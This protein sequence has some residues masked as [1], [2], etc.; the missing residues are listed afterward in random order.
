[1]GAEGIG[2]SGP[3]G[4]PE[5]VLFRLSAIT[6]NDLG[7]G[8][9]LLEELFRRDRHALHRWETHLPASRQRTDVFQPNR[10]T[11]GHRYQLGM[12]R[13]RDDTPPG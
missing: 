5:S 13:P 2:S 12:G 11:G 9:S 1:M 10:F 6:R 4:S 8:P 7:A 3:T